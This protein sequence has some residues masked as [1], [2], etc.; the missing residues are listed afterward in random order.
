VLVSVLWLPR[1]V[2]QLR[3]FQPPPRRDGEPAQVVTVGPAEPVGA[4]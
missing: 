4:S 3:R 1:F 2:A